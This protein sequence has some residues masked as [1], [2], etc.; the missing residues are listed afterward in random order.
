MTGLRLVLCLLAAVG[1]I[2]IG[3]G[4]DDESSE[5]DGAATS[6]TTST[7]VS[8]SPGAEEA[9][10]FQ[11]EIADLSDEEQISAIG[12]EWAK[13]FG[14]GDEKMCGYLHPDIS[15]ETA[16]SGYVNGSMTGSSELQSSFSGATVEDVQ[17]E[18]EEAFAEFDTGN[19]VKFTPAPDGTWAIIATPRAEA[20]GSDKVNQPT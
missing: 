19:T 16:C 20:S 6:T 4:G 18:G 1:L 12:D 7:T 8:D 3:C 15:G 14:D 9:A 11:E 5:D 17:I 10:A 2:G 13:L